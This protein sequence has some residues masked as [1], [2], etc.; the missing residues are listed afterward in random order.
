MKLEIEIPDS[1]L[2]ALRQAPKDF[3]ADLRLMA[4]AKWYELG[5]LSQERAAELADLSR[6]KFLDRLSQ[7]RVSPFQGIE[8]DL[9]AS[10]LAPW[11]SSS[12]PPL[13]S[14]SPK[15]NS[16]TVSPRSVTPSWFHGP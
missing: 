4:A 10:S 14:F 5:E 16:W 6:Q 7:L 2:S 13:S 8:N 9:N 1:T 3:S 12:M 11:L 15:L